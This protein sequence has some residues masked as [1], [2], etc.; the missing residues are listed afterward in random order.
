VRRA[1]ILDNPPPQIL[2]Q[3][4]ELLLRGPAQVQVQAAAVGMLE[5]LRPEAARLQ[6]RNRRLDMALVLEG[7]GVVP[8]RRSLEQRLQDERV[9][10]RLA[11]VEFLPEM[12]PESRKADRLQLT[13]LPM[14]AHDEE[15]DLLL[16]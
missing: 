9:R 12:L 2:L 15:H 10:L 6:P 13:A 3:D 16:G 14:R 4:R 5:K 1:S 7:P 8:L 11:G